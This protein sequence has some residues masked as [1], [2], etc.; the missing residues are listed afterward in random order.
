MISSLLTFN[1]VCAGGSLLERVQAEIRLL[2]EE[3][4]ETGKK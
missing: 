2:Q 1:V 4:K 3:I